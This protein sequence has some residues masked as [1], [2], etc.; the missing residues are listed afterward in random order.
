MN[1]NGQP[2]AK[3]NIPDLLDSSAVGP[4]QKR[5]FVLCLIA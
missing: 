4:L 3:I 1:V 2:A 5:V